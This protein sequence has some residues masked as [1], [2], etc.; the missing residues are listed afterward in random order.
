MS[1]HQVLVFNLTEVV[2]QHVART[3]FNDSSWLLG[4]SRVLDRK[5]LASPFTVCFVAGTRHGLKTYS[6]R[7]V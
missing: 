6:V 7:L 5:T 1:Q 4:M 3:W 2:M